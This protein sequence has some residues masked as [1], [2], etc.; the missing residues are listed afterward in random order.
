MSSPNAGVLYVVG[1]G[2]LTIALSAFWVG[3][4]LLDHEY[5]TDMKYGFR[6][7]GTHD[8]FWDMFFDLPQP[9]DVLVDRAGDH[10]LV[11]SIARRHVIGVAL[12]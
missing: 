8:S 12:G 10:R 2:V 11:A 4:F 5:M 6:P 3:P 7:S 9:F 1:V